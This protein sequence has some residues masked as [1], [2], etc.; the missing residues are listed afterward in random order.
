VAAALVLLVEDD[1]GI[2]TGLSRAL[3][4]EGYDVIATPSGRE[5]LAIVGTADVKPDVALLDL[6]LPDIDGI[7]VCTELIGLLPA[8]PIIVLTA[9]ADEL[10]I[11]VGLDAGAVDYITKP[12]GLA[13]LLARIRVQLRRPPLPNDQ[14]AIGDLAL[15]PASRRAWLGDHELAL[16]RKEFDL[17]AALVNRAG[18]V[19]TREELMTEVWDEH[20]YGSTKTLDVH[21]AALRRKLDDDGHG[22]V[23]ITTLRG[24]GYRLEPTC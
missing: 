11:V 24:V 7:D 22:L 1:V 19:V 2:T 10:D 21:V 13:E 23:A 4:G 14:I 3:K 9:R 17:L 12:F 16:R 6:G 15:D 5:A 18:Q 20:W 8:M